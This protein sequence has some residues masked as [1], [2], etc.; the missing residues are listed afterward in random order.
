M[1]LN[2]FQLKFTTVSLTRKR[3]IVVS[4]LRVTNQKGAMLIF[5]QQ[6]FLLCLYS[7][8]LSE[9][10]TV[11]GERKKFW[12]QRAIN[13]EHNCHHHQASDSSRNLHK[14][15]NFQFHFSSST[16]SMECMK[17]LHLKMNGW[18]PPRV[19]IQTS[20][21]SCSKFQV[22]RQLSFIWK[23]QSTPFFLRRGHLKKVQLW[24]IYRV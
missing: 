22:H 12:G 7:L 23:I 8:D 24:V 2:D 6:K 1:L 19:K 4:T 15:I 21:K 18:G 16:S 3:V 5:R 14:L 13:K 11:K 9:V 10:P 17:F 20:C